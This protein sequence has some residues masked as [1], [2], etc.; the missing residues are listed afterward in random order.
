[1][2]GLTRVAL[3]FAGGPVLAVFLPG[4]ARATAPEFFIVGEVY[5]EV[6]RIN[7][8]NKLSEPM[9]GAK[10]KLECKGEEAGN[11]TY[12][13]EGETNESGRIG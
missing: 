6:C 13:Q 9:P 4:V 1:M 11:I 2:S 3:L 12:T 5:C 10:V 8:I 7:F